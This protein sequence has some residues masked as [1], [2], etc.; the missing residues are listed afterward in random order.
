MNGDAQNTIH[1]IVIF[2]YAN[3]G[4][5]RPARTPYEVFVVASH[6]CL[7]IKFLPSQVCLRDFS[8]LQEMIRG[9]VKIAF[10]KGRLL[11]M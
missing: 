8:F 1:A 7:E 11:K 5:D 3:K 4:K 10:R 2:S 6:Y 9:F